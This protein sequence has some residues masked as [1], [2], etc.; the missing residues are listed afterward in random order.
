MITFLLFVIG[1][2]IGSFLNVVAVR[3]D[4]KKFLFG[5]HIVKGRSHCLKCTRTLRW[6]ELVPLLSFMVLEG[7]CRTCRSKFSLQ[8]FFAELISACV[9]VGIPYVMPNSSLFLTTLWIGAA[10]ALLLMSLIDLRLKL[11]PDEV[12]IILI[13][14]GIIR[15]FVESRVF[16]LGNTSF[17]SKYALLF[18]I[19]GNM[20]VNHLA[21]AAIGIVLF[22]A[23]IVMTRGRGMGIGDAKLVFALGILFGWPDVLFIIVFAFVL[24][25]LYGLWK[26]LS[27][28][29]RLKSAVP[30]GPFLALGALTVFLWGSQILGWYFSLFRF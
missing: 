4:P 25:A 26:M 22:A 5:A 11:I 23:L 10:E 19:A 28:S 17:V 16:I 1:A 30:F 7:R 15:V 12:H 14:L 8:Y 13:A 3:Y 6:F 9:F 24:G 2:A 27:G 20:W 18:G 29:A 21:A